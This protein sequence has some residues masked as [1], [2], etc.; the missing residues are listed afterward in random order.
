HAEGKYMTK[1]ARYK[2]SNKREAFF[3]QEMSIAFP[4]LHEV[5][6][7]YID[8]FVKDQILYL[9]IELKEGR[10][11]RLEQFPEALLIHEKLASVSYLEAAGFLSIA[12]YRF[13]FNLR[14]PNIVSQSFT[15][16]HKETYNRQLFSALRTLVSQ[17]EH[18]DMVDFLMNRL[19]AL[20]M[21]NH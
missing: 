8:S 3:Y 5:V 7:A 10:F 14:N 15:H 21:D 12:S 18:P 17:R 16:I 4:F 13:R 20:V 1:I 6:P 9:T 2:G 19:G 11:A